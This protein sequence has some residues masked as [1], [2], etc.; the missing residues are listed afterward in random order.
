VSSETGSASK[1]E[2]E[3]RRIREEL[4]REL[5][6][7]IAQELARDG[8][9]SQTHNPPDEAEARRE[10]LIAR[11]ARAIRE[12][13]ERQVRAAMAGETPSPRPSGTVSST[14][15]SS[16]SHRA[17]RMSPRTPGSGVAQRL[18]SAHYT[19]RSPPPPPPARPASASARDHARTE[20]RE[21]AK[22]VEAEARAEA[23]KRQPSWERPH[24]T[25][26]LPSA[27]HRA[28]ERER[29]RPHT[30][31]TVSTRRSTTL[32]AS[33]VSSANTASHRLRTP[34]APRAAAHKPRE[35]APSSTPT[36]PA[37]R[38]GRGALS[39]SVGQSWWFE[40]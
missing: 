9:A 33:A 25:P 17:S 30:S 23:V 14:P 19:L 26:P 27:A 10:E 20:A 38:S 5:R 32:A 13:V 40:F 18:S 2:E 4:R 15:S 29:E 12:D 21:W 16:S 22:R 31:G 8:P 35:L 7:T 36:P 6:E 24:N 11:E 37:R 28:R 3:A 39:P 1:V 34:P